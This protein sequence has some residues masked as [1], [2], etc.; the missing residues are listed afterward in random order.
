MSN[1]GGWRDNVDATATTLPLVNRRLAL[2]K[3]F[4]KDIT[5]N[6]R[7]RQKI[8]KSWEYCAKTDSLSLKPTLVWSSVVSSVSEMKIKQFTWDLQR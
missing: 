5:R 4:P 8:Y 1:V 2:L 6:V 3:E 7:D